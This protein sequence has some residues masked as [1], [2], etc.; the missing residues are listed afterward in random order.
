MKFHKRR[1]AVAWACFGLALAPPTAHAS[2][3][4][5][6]H[7]YA[8]TTAAIDLES[9]GRPVTWQR[10]CDDAE[11]AGQEIRRILRALQLHARALAALA[12]SKSFD[13]SGLENM[14][15]GIGSVATATAPDLSS[16][17]GI[18]VTKAGSAVASLTG[19]FVDG[20][21]RGKLDEAVEASDACMTR[22]AGDLDDMLLAVDGELE[23]AERQQRAV[24][25]MLLDR[26]WQPA[27]SPGHL[28]GAA[29]ELTSD[30]ETDFARIKE[31]LIRYGAAVKRL[32]E[33]YHLL[34]E[35]ARSK[36][37]ATDVNTALG[38][39]D[40]SVDDLLDGEWNR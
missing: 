28:V 30:A 13:A 36:A 15:S 23:V 21:R 3:E 17:A 4:P 1:S 26:R 38:N 40:T 9:A 32:S 22:V 39:L 27:D 25:G 20:Y 34:A 8:K 14:A 16:S 18:T 37:S 6:P 5:W 24:V 19:K 33:A 12:E 29:F 11:R 31:S 2:D 10:D 7:W 35:L